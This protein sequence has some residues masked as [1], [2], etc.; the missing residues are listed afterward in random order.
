MIQRCLNHSAVLWGQLAQ[1]S[2]S[3]SGVAR[4]HLAAVAH[5]GGRRGA[6]GAQPRARRVRRGALCAADTRRAAALVRGRVDSDLHAAGSSRAPRVLTQHRPNKTKNAQELR[7]WC[8]AQARPCANAHMRRPC[9]A[10]MRT[11]SKARAPRASLDAARRE[12]AQW[13]VACARTCRAASGAQARTEPCELV[14]NTSFGRQQGAPRAP[15][16]SSC[17]PSLRRAPAVQPAPSRP[18]P[19]R[20]PDSRRPCT[21]C[22][23]HTPIHAALG[24][25][26]NRSCVVGPSAAAQE[27]EDRLAARP[28]RA[29]HKNKTGGWQGSAGRTRAAGL[30]S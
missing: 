6:A 17:A 4:A 26:S 7:G 13:Y 2:V 3:R 1:L 19:A 25:V 15:A 8:L 30:R 22:S 27:C 14:T 23:T 18:R 20:A 28:R 24:G 5:P 16:K 11:S 21:G 9:H 10:H 29:K 12:E